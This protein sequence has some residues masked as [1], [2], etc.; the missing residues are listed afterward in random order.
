MAVA[1]FTRHAVRWYRVRRLADPDVPQLIQFARLLDAGPSRPV[2]FV[3][4]D[5]GRAAAASCDR[6]M[7][8]VH[9]IAGLLIQG[10]I[11]EE[12]VF[13][14]GSAKTTS[15]IRPILDESLAERL[16]SALSTYSGP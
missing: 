9:A 16:W 2:G 1:I 7:T 3:I 14:L 10:S 6:L 15:V 11:R 4:D 12:D 13:L 5:V 8:E